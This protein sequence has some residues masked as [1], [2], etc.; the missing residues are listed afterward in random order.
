MTIA[1]ALRETDDFLIS[2]TGEDERF[3]GEVKDFL[4]EQADQ[5]QSPVDMPEKSQSFS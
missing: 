5:L 4:Y 3:L 2:A 1:K